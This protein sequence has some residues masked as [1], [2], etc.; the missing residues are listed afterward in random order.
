[1]LWKVEHCVVPCFSRISDNTLWLSPTENVAC[2]SLVQNTLKIVRPCNLVHK[3]VTQ[4]RT[5][6]PWNTSPLSHLVWNVAW[7]APKNVFGV[8]AISISRLL[9]MSNAD[10]STTVFALLKCNSWATKCQHH[11]LTHSDLLP[12]MYQ[13]HATSQQYY[14]PIHM[15]EYM[16]LSVI[17]LHKQNTQYLGTGICT[18]LMW[19]MRRKNGNITV[20]RTNNDYCCKHH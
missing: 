19:C 17:S 15:L 6:Y 3:I 9:T 4:L 1:M 13:D 8:I 11:L 7:S 16:S 12:H 2:V 14:H 20:V 5:Y 10:I 18:P